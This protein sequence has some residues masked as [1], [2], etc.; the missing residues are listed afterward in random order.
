[1]PSGAPTPATAL[2]RRQDQELLMGILSRLSDPVRWTFV[3]FEIYG[4]TCT[5]IAAQH[6][7]P[8]TTVWARLLRGRRKV[9][10]LLI[11]RQTEED[12]ASHP[13]GTEADSRK[14]TRLSPVTYRY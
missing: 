4:F 3:L 5:E 8:T 6:H 9:F 7:V 13:S 2:E 14:Q 11:E 12:A 10:A 1:M